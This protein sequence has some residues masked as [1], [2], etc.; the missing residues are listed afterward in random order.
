MST[1]LDRNYR[2]DNGIYKIVDKDSRTIPFRPN[3]AQQI[4]YAKKQELR[5]AGFPI[6]LIILKGRQMGITTGE[7]IYNFDDVYWHE[8]L[9]AWM[10]AHKKDTISSIFSKVE[11]AYSRLPENLLIKPKFRSRNEFFWPQINSSMRVTADPTGETIDRLHVCEVALIRNAENNLPQFIQG[12]PKYSGVVV[13]ESTAYGVGGY[14]YNEW[15]RAMEMRHKTLPG[16]FIPIFLPWTLDDQYKSPVRGQFDPPLSEKEKYLIKA[17][18]LSVEQVQWRREKI[19]ELGGREEIFAQYY[20]LTPEEAFISSGFPI[21]DQEILN[22][23][24]HECKDPIEVKHW[25][26]GELRAY[27]KR[28]VGADYLISVDTSEGTGNDRSAAAIIDLRDFSI[29]AV[30]HGMM[31]PNNL[32]RYLARLGIWFNN[33]TIAVERNNHG[34]SVLNTLMN[35][36]GYENVYKHRDYDQKGRARLKPGFPTTSKT[37]P[38]ILDDLDEAISSGELKIPDRTM[39]GELLQFQMIDGKPQAPL[40]GYDDLVM[41]LAIG[42]HLRK[43]VKMN[44]SYPDIKVK[45]EGF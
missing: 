15:Q 13:L 45:P 18:N 28:E 35:H 20:P 19:S 11:F 6:R 43:G 40:D 14:F 37:R 29:T 31:E 21:F 23:Q 5:K 30:L 36:E 24:L 1:I 44:R 39:I 8:N 4:I 27:A 12:V 9:R 33:A 3:K 22:R 17:H 2:L 26:G 41:A 32:G 7:C 34:H 38:L 25:M 10:M 42:I 16:S